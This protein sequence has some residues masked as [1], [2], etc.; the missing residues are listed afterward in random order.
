MQ[1]QHY[2][3]E[4]WDQHIFRSVFEL[5]EYKVESFNPEDIILDIGGHIGSFSMLV[6]DKGSR[7]VWTFEPDFNNYVLA[8]NNTSPYPEIQ[9]LNTAVVGNKD[10]FRKFSGYPNSFNTGG[11]NVGSSES[12]ITVNATNIN[13]ILS[14]IKD[15]NQVVRLIKL[16]CEGSEYEIIHNIKD[17]QKIQEFVGEY[18]GEGMEALHEYLIS[19]GFTGSYESTAQETG[20]IIGKFRYKL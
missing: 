7:N 14:F 20:Q 4:T 2:R 6:Y 16:D 17:I 18:H 15:K 3:Q 9:V 10:R 19:K 5:N 13:D 11:G 1:L 12:T 8:K